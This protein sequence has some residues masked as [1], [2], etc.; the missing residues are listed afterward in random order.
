MGGDRVR[1]PSRTGGGAAGAE[2]GCH[3]AG[4]AAIQVVQRAIS[5]VPVVIAA[6][7][8]PLAFGF[9]ASL[10]RPGGNITGLSNVGADLSGKYLDLLHV[11]IP[12]CRGLPC[13]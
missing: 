1:A 6:S 9:V 10:S 2:T 8:D 11:A 4:P 3:R 13:W 7:G 12:N 5:T